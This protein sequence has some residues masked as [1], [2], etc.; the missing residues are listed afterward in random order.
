MIL[1][2]YIFREILKSQLVTLVVLLSVFLCQSMVR[3]ISKSA[4]G[5][6]PVDM[7]YQMVVYSV[8][9]IAYLML[10][11]SLF[12]AVLMTVGRICSDSEMVVMRSVGFSERNILAIALAL[13][14]VTAAAAAVNSLWFMPEA[15]LQQQILK[16]KAQNNPQYL[17]IESGRFV[18]FDND[19]AE[20]VIFIEN[21]QGGARD[22][23]RLGNIYVMTNTFRPQGQAFTASVKGNLKTEDDGSQWLNLGAGNRYEGPLPNLS[24]RAA[25]FDSLR[26]PAGQAEEN[27]SD[28][29]DVTQLPTAQLWNSDDRR[30][31]LELQWRA[32]PII[33]V[34]I[35]TMIAVPLSMVN[36]RQ[37]RFSRLW[38]AILLYVAYYLLLL[39]FRNMINAGKLWIFPG[40]YLVP[41]IFIALAV[42]P[43]NLHQSLRRARKKQAA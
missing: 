35:L 41:L 42:V 30:L 19:K 22:Q 33:G 10:P 39:S 29:D 3:Y 16:K 2:R 7:I 12:V 26:L 5:D 40:L 21:V 6:T 36:P 17:P 4:E 24:H 18:T 28:N 20:Q 11:L 38:Q 37:G 34:F 13:A 14:A 31:T 1:R 32:A 23:R 8:P 9:S 43:L 25:S 15:A 27:D